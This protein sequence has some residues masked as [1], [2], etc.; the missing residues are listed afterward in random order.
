MVWSDSTEGGFMSEHFLS[1][2]KYSER[3]TDVKTDDKSKEELDWT[4]GENDKRFHTGNEGTFNGL[5][6]INK[7]CEA[8]E[9]WWQD[10]E[11]SRQRG[12]LVLIP[13]L[14]FRPSV[15]R[16]H[17]KKLLEIICF[18]VFDL[19]N[20]RFQLKLNYNQ[21]IPQQASGWLKDVTCCPV[22][23]R[24]LSWSYGASGTHCASCAP[25]FV[26]IFS[27]CIWGRQFSI[28][29]WKEENRLW[30][31]C[32]GMCQLHA[33]TLHAN[34]HL[35]PHGPYEHKQTYFLQK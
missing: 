3:C 21:L 1:W 15:Y 6:G 14:H 10:G 7:R 29:S 27:S 19:L 16:R 8:I 32:W 11:R 5:M 2:S 35:F 4:S 12:R 31:F 23:S 25:S 20:E 34:S 9:H 30:K 18:T 13:F 22:F 26:I 28:N 24:W 17:W 33:W